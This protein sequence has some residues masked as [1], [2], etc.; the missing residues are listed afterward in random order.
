MRLKRIQGELG[1]QI[2]GGNLSGIF[3]ESLEE[4]SPA[5]G[6]DG[7]LPG[8]LILE[9]PEVIDKVT[10]NHVVLDEST[11]FILENVVHILDKFVKSSSC[12]FN[13]IIKIDH[14][15]PSNN[16]PSKSPPFIFSGNCILLKASNKIYILTSRPFVMSQN[17]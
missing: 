13:H 7:L 4:D 14:I 11:F 6:P 10:M 9:V 8:D 2:C 16:L 12:S 15:S 5:R 17:A 1:I 3:V